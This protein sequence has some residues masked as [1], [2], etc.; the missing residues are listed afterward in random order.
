MNKAILMGR[1][2]RDPEV[3]YSQSANPVAVAR[4]G[5]AVRR[6]FVKPGEQDVDFFNIVAFGKAGEFAEKYFKK[7][8]MVSIVGRLQVNTWEDQQKVKH[9]S[10]DVVA[11]E[12]HF[13]ESKSSFEA[14]GPM[15]VQP[16]AP[17]PSPSS[18]NSASGFMPTNN[19]EEDDDLPF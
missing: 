14:R 1:L 6:S 4:Y 16:S 17:T 18:G 3:R 10:V 9:T 8:Q 15:D 13:A 19:F 12:Q 11:E 7:G 2:T 5:L